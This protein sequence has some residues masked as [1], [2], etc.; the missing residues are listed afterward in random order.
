[1][2]KLSSTDV[3]GILL[4]VA[5]YMM[6][7]PYIAY[8]SSDIFKYFSVNGFNI[9][10]LIGL[11]PLVAI[12]FGYRYAYSVQM[13]ILTSD[14]FKKFLENNRKSMLN[15]GIFLFNTKEDVE[16]KYYPNT[17]AYAKKLIPVAI[18]III[19]TFFISSRSSLGYSLFDLTNFEAIS[20]YFGLVI[21]IFNFY[22][23]LNKLSSNF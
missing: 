5:T 17:E 11:L 22:P 19:L 14:K 23:K 3:L 1:M 13:D 9:L 10:S 8:F 16:K 21:V 20:F 2:N 7:G 4:A 6:I 18:L 12:Y 15:N